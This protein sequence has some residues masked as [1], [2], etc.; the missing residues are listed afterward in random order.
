MKKSRNVIVILTGVLLLG[1]ILIPRKS[2]IKDGES[3]IDETNQ[4]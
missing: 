1:I 2:E 4:L 3:V